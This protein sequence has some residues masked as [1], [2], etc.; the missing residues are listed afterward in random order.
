MRSK[1]VN[2]NSATSIIRPYLKQYLEEKGI[3]TSKKFNCI[4]PKHQDSNPSMSCHSD[5]NIHVAHCF[6][7]HANADI[8]TAANFLENK[9]LKGAEFITDNVLYL[10]DKFGIKVELEDLTPEEIYEYRSYEAYKLAAE[11]I[12][13][14]SFGDYSLV[15]KEIERRKWDPEKCAQWGIGT[16]NHDEYKARMKAAGFDKTFLIGVDLERSNLFD[17][18]NLLFTVYDDYG[19]PVGFS[20]KN[21]KHVPEDK[22]SGSKYINTKCT[23]LECAIFKKGE[24]LYGF[25]IARS[26]NSPLYIFEG[27][28]DVITARHYGMMNCCCP[29]GT[30]LSSYHINLLKKHGIFN[31]ILVFD[32]DKAGEEATLKALDT[33][34]AIEKDFRIKLIQLP[35][36]QDPDELLRSKGI[37]EFIRL[38]K[39]SAFEWRMMQFMQ[40]AGDEIDEEKKREIAEKMS[41]IIVTEKSHVRQE[42]MAKQVAKMTG[43]TI[44]TIMSEVK[45]LR[46]E[47]EAMI[48]EKKTAAIESLLSNIRYNP[49]EIELTLTECQSIINNINK[50]AEENG[51]KKSP[52][53]FI[54]SQKELD[55]QKGTEFSGY[56]MRPDGLFENIGRHLDDDWSSGC[57]FFIGG[58]EQSGKCQKYDSKVLLADGTYKEI[59]KVVKDKD[60][61]I[62]G[63]TE[64]YRLKPLKISNWIDSGELECFRLETEAGLYTEPSETH[65]YFT[66]E[67]WKKVK[68]LKIG[69]RIAIAR[70]YDCFDNLRSP[71]SKEEAVLL[72]AFLSDGSLTSKVGFSNTDDELISYFKENINL[73]WDNIIHGRGNCITEWLKSF[74]LFNKDAHNKEIPDVIFKSSLKRIGLFLGMLWACDGWVYFNPENN[75]KYEVGLSLCNHKMIKQIR[76]LLLRYGIKTKITT[77]EV[78]L[79][80]KSFTRHT[81]LIKDIENIKKFYNNIKIPL[82]YKQNKIKNILDSNKNS[83]SSYND[84][85]PSELWIRIKQKAEEKGWTLNYLL[86]VIG[87]DKNHWTYDKIKD[88]YKETVA[89]KPKTKNRKGEYQL[90]QITPRKLNLIG[91]VLQDQFLIDLANGDIYFD[92]ITS[93][94]PI[95]K[96]QCYDL[97]IPDNHNFIV[98]DTVVH[99]T[100]LATQIAYEI[101]TENENTLCIYHSIDDPAK[102]ILYK[103]IC[104]SVNDLKLQLNHVSNP[105]YH[106]QNEV[107][108]YIKETRDLGYNKIMS[109]FKD[110]RLMLLDS[111][112]GQSLSY[113][114]SVVKRARENNPSKRIVLFIDNFHKLPDHAEINGHER[115][116]RL[117]NHIKNM[118][119]INNISIISTVEYRKLN[120]GEKPSNQAIA[121]SRALQYDA[122]VII[123]LYNDLHM[124]GE[125]SHQ[126]HLAND[127]TLLPRIWCKFGKNKVSGYEGREYLDLYPYHAT[128]RPVNIEQAIQEMKERKRMLKETKE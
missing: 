101:A 88:C 11:L 122:S 44:Q 90:T 30:A 97:E 76:S 84:N 109:L 49:E 52:I 57:L 102:F 34:F 103:W 9:P 125:D 38:K 99:N 91:L 14:R 64:D 20:A 78:S 63:M 65:P 87:E 50:E 47:K 100:T 21:L 17:N 119:V 106:I 60:S 93:I 107:I 5:P 45:R 43:Y 117:S 68:D 86:K 71:I 79:N 69:D 16:V 24:R 2:L 112:D 12:S 123:H 41:Q 114:E 85:F 39:W 3:D 27:Q 32:S 29:L 35:N 18:H 46:F 80:G 51:T 116:K 126:V 36:G 4:N 74:N 23:G 98:E 1:V 7:C 8:F 128:Y 115:I 92:K 10:A 73:K 67:G 70:N 62:I 33:K 40:E 96:H 121:E 111:S 42:E 113:I 105:N 108:P 127:G 53:D 110:E 28:A 54:L 58:G 56:K 31:I 59:E 83:I 94:N 61:Y 48:Q 118:T 15:E 19:R 120:E 66:L 72:G 75:N 89:W 77:G 22:N 104:Q 13:D 6:S 37:D 25:D 82:S 26:A 55:E 95:G 81:L 124:N